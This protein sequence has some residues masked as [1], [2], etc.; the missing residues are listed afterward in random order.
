MSA[1]RPTAR[2]V[3]LNLELGAQ[4]VL[5]P[6][7]CGCLLKALGWR[8]HLHAVRSYEKL[9]GEGMTFLDVDVVR[10]LE[11][12]LPA[13]F[14]G[15]PMQYQLVE[16]EGADGRARLRL[17]VDPGVG[18]LDD[19]AVLDAFLEAIAP[20]SG[21]ERLMGLAWRQAGLV[22]VERRSPV[23]TGAGKILHLHQV[24]GAGAP[25]PRAHET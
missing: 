8:V 21:P 14:G 5:G 2:F 13:R 19:D 23:A 24:R 11:E 22:E 6:R 15:D 12:V 7:A 9:T 25:G 3:V 18:P 4:A 16:D 1:L 10:V 17:V 20:G